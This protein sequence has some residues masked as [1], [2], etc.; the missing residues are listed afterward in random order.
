[1]EQLL[2]YYDNIFD[3]RFLQRESEDSWEEMKLS[4]EKM[5][6]VGRKMLLDAVVDHCQTTI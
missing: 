3:L 2:E 4:M 6:V 1:M 5:V